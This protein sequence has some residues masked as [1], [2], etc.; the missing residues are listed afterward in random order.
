MAVKELNLPGYLGTEEV[1]ETKI[2]TQ[3]Q[4]YD[5]KWNRYE[6][7]EDLSGITYCAGDIRPYNGKWYLY[8]DLEIEQNFNGQ[9]DGIAKKY[10]VIDILFLIDSPGFALPDWLKELNT[11]T[12]T[13]DISKK[14]NILGLFE[15]VGEAK[16]SG[17]TNRMSDYQRQI[18]NIQL[19]INY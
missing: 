17:Y 13:N 14:I 18:G 5:A 12:S 6:K 7:C 8:L 10:C 19:Y 11:D 4:M 9:V 16:T 3:L 1:V 15:Q 2:E